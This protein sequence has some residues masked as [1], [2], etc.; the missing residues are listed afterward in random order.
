[1]TKTFPMTVTRL[2][3]PVTRMISTTSTVVYGFP[4]SR[5]LLS[6]EFRV[7]MLFPL[8]NASHG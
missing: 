7:S 6:D 8:V 5:L 3:H 1:M 4:E 2:K